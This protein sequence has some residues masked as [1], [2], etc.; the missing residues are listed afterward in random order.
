MESKK[1]PDALPRRGN[2]RLKRLESASSWFEVYQVSPGTFALL[3][4][5]HDEEVISYLV[6]GTKRAA[7]IDTGMGIGNIQEEVERLTDLPTIVINTHAH[8]DHIGD[9]HRFAEVWVFDEDNEVNR[10]ERGFTCA[11]CTKYMG[12][13][14]Y[15][16]LPSGFDPLA[17]EIQSSLVTRRLHHLDTIELGARTL[18]VHHTPGHS[19]GSICLLDS[20]DD[21]LFTGD[22]FYPGT[23]FA[24]FEDSDFE[25]YLKSMKYLVRF[26]DQVKHLCPAHNEAYAPR[27]M[28]VHVLEAFERI[29]A[30]QAAFE[31]QDETQVYRFEGFRVTLEKNRMHKRKT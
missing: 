20:R 18:T 25:A 5:N 14:S 8:F 11:E 26:L 12:S 27:E 22:T 24:H 4:P 3:E 10:V 31:L 19:P 13:D 23:L 2:Q 17:Y 28:L 16:N 6:L 21:L 7:L 30:G 15:M 9:D 29:A 1:W